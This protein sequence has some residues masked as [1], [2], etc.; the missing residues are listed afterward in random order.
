MKRFASAAKAAI[1][2]K[3]WYGALTLALTLPDICGRMESP[4]LGSQR[5]YEVWWDKYCLD[6]YRS[7][8]GP[9]RQIFTFLSG[10]DCYALRCAYLHEGGDDI[11]AQRARDAI[12]RF[13]FITPPENNNFIHNNFI[14]RN[15]ISVLQ[16]QIDAFANDICEG[17]ARWST[18]VSGKVDVQQRL[19]TLITIH[20]SSGAVIL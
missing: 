13:H 15:G 8:V 18:D 2:S 12:H 16:L 14:N 17:V 6:K 20:D 5:R 9:S 10:A 7:E 19:A 3:N 1:A 11:S 4:A